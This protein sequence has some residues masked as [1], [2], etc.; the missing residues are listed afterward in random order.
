MKYPFVIFDWDGTLIDSEARI[1]SSMQA[2]AV[3]AQ[4]PGGLTAEAVRNIIGLGLP[5]AIR[6]LC[7]GIDDEQLVKVREGYS[8]HFLEGS[9]LEMPK[10]EGVREGLERLKEAGCT[11]AVATGKSRRGLNRG[12]GDTGLDDLFTTSRCADET[13]SKPDPMMLN[14]LLEETGFSVREA[15]MVGDT[16][17]DLGMAKHAGMDSIAVNYGAHHPDRLTTYHPVLAVDHFIDLVDWIL[18]D[19]NS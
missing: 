18:S 16:E 11:L 14:E 13:C 19:D 7:P 3:D 10:F 15:V 5:E 4:W 6:E 17:F 12:L 8:Y 9:N 2:A 1:I